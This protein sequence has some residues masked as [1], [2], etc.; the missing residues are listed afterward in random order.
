MKTFI[1]IPAYNEEKRIGNVLKELKQNKYKNIVVVDD[2]SD[3][4]TFKEASKYKVIVLRHVVNRGQGA[5]LKTAI[6]Y[7]LKKGAELIVTFDADGQHSV[8]DIKNIV[9]P[10]ESKRYD[11]AVGSRF[12]KKNKNTPFIRRIFLK[13]GALI[14]FLM[15][16]IK[17]S[18]SHNGFRAMSRK[19]AKLIEI[20]SDGMEHASEIL[21]QIKK[22]DL[23]YKE[24][25]VIIKYTEYSKKKGQSTFNSFKILFK[26][27]M[28]WFIK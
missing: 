28:R 19:A 15:Y 6:D 3:D 1:V 4:N 7:A 9:K 23:K 27:I 17:L 2:G 24:V 12:L 13:G 20:K 11:V 8:G 21:E 26:M 16:G 25:S 14:I 22:K 5:A 18:D 10:V